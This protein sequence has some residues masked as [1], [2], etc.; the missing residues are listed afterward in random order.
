MVGE[1][2]VRKLIPGACLH[3]HCAFP[4]DVVGKHEVVDAVVMEVSEVTYYIIIIV[5]YVDFKRNEPLFKPTVANISIKMSYWRAGKVPLPC[6][7]H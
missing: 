5:H 2:A 4:L 6:P 3:A 7:S 1:L